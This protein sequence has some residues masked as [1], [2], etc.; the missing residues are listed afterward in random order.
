MLH[1][2]L[3]LLW[4]SIAATTE[5]LGVGSWVEI[6]H[7]IFARFC[8]GDLVLCCYEWCQESAEGGTMSAMRYS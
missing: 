3:Q 2:T 6:M 1:L 4:A 8:L 7:A 5:L